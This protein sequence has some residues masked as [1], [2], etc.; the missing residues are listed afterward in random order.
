MLG[1]LM[2]GDEDVNDSEDSEDDVWFFCQHGGDPVRCIKCNPLTGDPNEWNET[3][4]LNDTAIIDTKQRIKDLEDCLS[5]IL[6]HFRI[7]GELSNN[8][9]EHALNLLVKPLT[10]SE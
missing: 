9:R 3:H 10:N 6:K 8:A 4:Y 2:F 1:D 7:H 5:E